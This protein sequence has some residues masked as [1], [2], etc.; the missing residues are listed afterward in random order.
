MGWDEARVTLL[1]PRWRSAEVPQAVERRA[2]DGRR[3]RVF[4]S[5]RDPAATAAP[6]RLAPV[7]EWLQA[8]GFT[9][10]E[11]IRN[12]ANLRWQDIRA[13]LFEENGELSE[14]SLTFTLSVD[15]PGRWPVWQQFAEELCARFGL[16]LADQEAGEKVRAGH[17]LRLL[18]G[19][20]AWRE[21]QDH[22]RWPV[23][24]DGSAIDPPTGAAP[25]ELPPCF[26]RR[27]PND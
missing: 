18:A 13:E 12:G 27:T 3:V 25:V 22:F 26:S 23:P 15:S 24:P 17:L 14:V 10:V 4:D 16:L 8:R 21:F 19:T 6:V 7:R 11:P 9:E 20:T 1:P 5:R 2:F